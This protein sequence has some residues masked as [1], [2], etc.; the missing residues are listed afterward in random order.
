MGIDQEKPMD[1]KEFWC[2]WCVWYDQFGGG[3]FLRKKYTE[4]VNTKTNEGKNGIL[5]RWPFLFF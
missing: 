1:W 2:V 3:D 4:R 5:E